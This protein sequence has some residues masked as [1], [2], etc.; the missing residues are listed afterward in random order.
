MGAI[1]E[2]SLAIV[3]QGVKRTVLNGVPYDYRTGQYLV[4]SVDLPVIGQALEASPDE[5]FVV[6]SMSLRP[7]SSRRSCWRRPQL[8]RLPPS[9]GWR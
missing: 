9:P 8:V 3:A 7:G 5:P 4:V 2:P 1:S 6:F